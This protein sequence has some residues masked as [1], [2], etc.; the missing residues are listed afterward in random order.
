MKKLLGVLL[1]VCMVVG[2]GAVSA[3]ADGGLWSPE[4]LDGYDLS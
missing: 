1:A 3:S 4:P 2:V